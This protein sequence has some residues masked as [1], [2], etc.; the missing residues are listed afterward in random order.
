MDQSRE[1]LERLLGGTAETRGLTWGRQDQHSYCR[2]SL[3]VLLQH[4]VEGMQDPLHSYGSVR[5]NIQA[6][7]EENFHTS[8]YFFN[9]GEKT[10]RSCD[11]KMSR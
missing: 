6:M 11:I 2:S 3:R 5:G 10:L 8:P 1:V 9:W 7:S 4:Q